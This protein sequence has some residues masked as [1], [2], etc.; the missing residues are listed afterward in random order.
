MVRAHGLAS[1]ARRAIHVAACVI[2]AMVIAPAARG[3]LPPLLEIGGV[4]HFDATDFDEIFLQADGDGW[5]I[6]PTENAGRAEYIIGPNVGQASDVC[7]PVG[8]SRYMH[9]D[10]SL[11]A[12]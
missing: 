8:E 6:V 10:A 3:Q 9:I 4:I 2:V 1:D 7:D 12:S 11:M 5:E